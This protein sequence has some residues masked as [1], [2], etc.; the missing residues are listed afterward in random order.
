M[1]TRTSGRIVGALILLAF[2]FYGAGSGLVDGADNPRLV[3]VGVLL[4]LLN[5]FGVAR[6]GVVAFPVLSRTDEVSALAYLVTR[7]FEAV[8]LA[9]GAMVMIMT[10][11]VAGEY[12]YWFAMTGLALG[13][14]L[15]CGDAAPGAPRAAVP[16]GVGDRRVRR[17]GGR[18]DARDPRVRRRPGTLGAG[19]PVRVGRR[20]AAGGEGLPAAVLTQDLDASALEL[21]VASVAR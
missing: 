13:S 12:A 15:F 7:I 4:I 16:R 14:V 5:S 10:M 9:V 1:S 11:P 20:G 19:R 6:I 21:P 17:S 8:M 2:V 3:S 18:R